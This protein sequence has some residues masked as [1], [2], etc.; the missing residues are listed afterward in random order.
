MSPKITKTTK[1][2]LDDIEAPTFSLRIQPT[3][4]SFKY[5]RIDSV[6]QLNIYNIKTKISKLDTEKDPSL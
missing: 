3:F 4:V 5:W 6:L 1:E 2:G